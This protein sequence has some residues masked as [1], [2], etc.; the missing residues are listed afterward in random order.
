MNGCPRK[1]TTTT[2]VTRRRP[3]AA[4]AG[5][6]PN[7]SSGGL[8]IAVPSLQALA[9]APFA[10]GTALAECDRMYLVHQ[11]IS[12]AR[13]DYCPPGTTHNC[14]SAYYALDVNT[15]RYCR[16]VFENLGR[17]DGA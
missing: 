6:S 7:A 13:F 3:V 11:G 9:N 1:N 17:C 12:C 15:G 14:L 4:A 2:P 10:S 16:T 5:S 8:A